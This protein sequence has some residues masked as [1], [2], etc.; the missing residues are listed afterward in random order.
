M[1]GIH[2]IFHSHRE[3]CKQLNL[4]N[5]FRRKYFFSL[6]FRLDIAS[7]IKILYISKPAHTKTNVLESKQ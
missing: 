2:G 6:H 3:Y 4:Q 5:V 7:S 1:L